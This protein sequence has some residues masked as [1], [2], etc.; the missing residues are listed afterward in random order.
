V[1][2]DHDVRRIADQ[3][4]RS[5]DVRREDLDQNERHSRDPQQ[6]GQ[7]QRHRYDKQDRRQV[8]E[9]CR[10][11]GRGT[12]EQEDQTEWAPLRELRDPQRD[13]GEHTR[14]LRQRDQDHHPDQQPERFPV[15]RLDSLVDVE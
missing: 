4:R 6:I 15:D 1:R 12:G 14:A 7:K 13:V 11:H 3:G 9:K 10:Q 2:P 8:V 5:A